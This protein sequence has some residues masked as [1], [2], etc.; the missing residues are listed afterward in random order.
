MASAV[1]LEI[2]KGSRPAIPLLTM[3]STIK[4][5]NELLSF[6]ELTDP[7]TEEMKNLCGFGSPFDRG[8]Q[9]CLSAEIAR[10]ARQKKKIIH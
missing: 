4:M 6:R 7:V 8:C 2:S 10:G 9:K 5:H 1:L 3:G